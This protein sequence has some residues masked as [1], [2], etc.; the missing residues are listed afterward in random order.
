MVSTGTPPATTS[1]IAS[2]TIGWSSGSTPIALAPCL[3]VEQRARQRLGIEAVD[4]VDA[5]LRLAPPRLGDGGEMLR[6]KP[7]EGVGA[8]GQDE[9][10]SRQR[11]RRRRR[12]GAMVGQVAEP[13]GGVEHLVPRPRLDAGPVVERP[14][15]RRRADPGGARDLGDRR[16]ARAPGCPVA[17]V[18]VYRAL[19]PL[20][21]QYIS[22]DQVV[23]LR[24]GGPLRRQL[25]ARPAAC[26]QF[27]DLQQISAS[28]SHALS[29]FADM[30]DDA[31]VDRLKEY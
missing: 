26:S 13:D 7:E 22:F 3:E 6:E 15:D 24:F 29:R 5:D 8:A 9:V 4:V 12:G 18:I 21:R 2:R 10:D 25:F 20:W 31:R 19:Q 1:R 16:A 14:V 30:G 27:I 23:I 11:R 17:S 28:G